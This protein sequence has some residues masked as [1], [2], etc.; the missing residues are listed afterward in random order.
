M[1]Y[2]K[3]REH[4]DDIV[5]FLKMIYL[6]CRRYRRPAGV[7]YQMMMTMRRTFGVVLL[8]STCVQV[9]ACQAAV[10]R[11]SMGSLHIMV[12]TPLLWLIYEVMPCTAA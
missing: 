7:D 11:S 12:G 1:L 9:L 4:E 2:C 8:L 10:G 6:C 5:S 3:R